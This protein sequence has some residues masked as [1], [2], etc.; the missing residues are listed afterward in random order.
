MG[1]KRQTMIHDLELG[2]DGLVYAVDMANDTLVSLDP[3]S[4]ERKEYRVPG[5]KEPN[6]D[7]P[8]AQGPHSL[9]CDADGNH[10]DHLRDRRQDGQIRRENQRVAGRFVSARSGAARRLSAH[11]A[12][13]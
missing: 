2:H 4:G 11:A 10:L 12:R 6:S 9:E 7:E 1:Y 13:R 5:G 3:T 8:M